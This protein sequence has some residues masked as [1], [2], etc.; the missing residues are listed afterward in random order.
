M[1]RKDHAEVWK[2]VVGFE[3]HYAVSDL[4]QV[5]RVKAAKGAVVGGILRA[6]PNTGGYLHVI[7]HMDDEPTDVRIHHLVARAFLGVC[8]AGFE[9]HHIPVAGVPW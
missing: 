4:G 1:K 9:V 7:L 3:E 8:P 6:S 2:P 5:K